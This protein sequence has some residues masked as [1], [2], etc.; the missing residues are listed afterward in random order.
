MR[1]RSRAIQEEILWSCSFSD[2]LFRFVGRA[3]F[4]VVDQGTGRSHFVERDL[5]FGD[6]DQEPRILRLRL[7]QFSFEFQR[8]R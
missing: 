4:R 8:A 6:I 1:S 5:A 3:F 7:Q 2:S